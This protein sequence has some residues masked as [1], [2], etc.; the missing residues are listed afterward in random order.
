MPRMDRASTTAYDDVFY[1]GHPFDET[2]P[3]H[4]ATLASLYGMKPAPVPCCRVLELGCGV[5]GN[6][7]PMAYQWPD[8][9]FVGID[10]SG[11]SI[12]HGS[13]TVAAIGLKNVRLR[14]FDIMEVGAEFGE[15]DYIIAHGV[16]SWVPQVVREKILSIFKTNLAPQGVAYVSYNAYPGS[17]QREIAR[18]AMLYGARQIADPAAKVRQSRALM[19]FLV[20]A[21]PED[22]LYGLML[23]G[24]DARVKRMSD[25]LLYHDDLNEIS[26]PSWLHEVAGSAA[27]HGLQYLCDATFSRSNLHNYSQRVVEQLGRIPDAEV[28]MREQYLDFV[29]GHGFRKTLLCHNDVALCR[30]IEPRCVEGYWLAGSPRPVARDTDPLAAGETLFK[31][32]AGH[33]LATDHRLGKAALLCLGERWPQA[34][35]FADLLQDAL[36]RLGPE[37]DEV[38]RNLDEESEALAAGLFRA[39]AAGHVQLHLHPPP[40]TTAISERP[41]ASLLARHE[42]AAG[43]FLTSLRHIAVV[44]DDPGIRALLPLLDGSRTMDDIVRDLNDA[45]TRASSGFGE[46][47]A[48]PPSDSPRVTSETVAN[49]LKTLAVLGFLMA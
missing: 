36:G 13:R 15:F 46:E 16:Y 30:G 21:T 7:V 1:P 47:R 25:E 24:Q 42:A 32:A 33:A 28:V 23:R 11:G 48:E 37:A 18:A 6:L 43:S 20:E 29:E 49:H 44:M 40:L 8:S 10:L 14:Q 9:T 2:H 41:R 5:G 4:L 35:R 31:T 34:L 22:E 12:A 3:D 45:L 38:V 19:Q 39:F 27:D 17:Y 26:T